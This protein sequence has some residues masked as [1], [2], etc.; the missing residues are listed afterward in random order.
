MK[1]RVRELFDA[2]QGMTSKELRDQWQR[3]IRG[4]W[5]YFSY[6]N[7]RTDVESLTGWFVTSANSSGALLQPGGMLQSSLPIGSERAQSGYRGLPLW[8][9]P[10]ATLVVV[11]QVV[12]NTQHAKYGFNVPW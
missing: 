8:A 11:K 1:N 12:C 4:W 5:H 10:M 6:A 9:W 3:Y 2:P 7:W